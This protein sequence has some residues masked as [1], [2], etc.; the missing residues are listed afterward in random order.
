MGKH[1]LSLEVKDTLNECVICVD[2]TSIYADKPPV[3]CPYL[4]ILIP[5]FS[6]AVRLD[7]TP[8]FCGLCLTA[9]DLELQT[10]KSQLQKIHH[11]E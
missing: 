10:K 11:T 7:V 4:D 8:G 2:D 9:C 1:T 3:E 5:G 6:C